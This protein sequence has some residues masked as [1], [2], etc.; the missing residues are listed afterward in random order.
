M[1]E[2]FD[3]RTNKVKE[4]LS[5]S[6]ARASA[7]TLYQATG[8]GIKVDYATKDFSGMIRTLKTMLEYA[9]NLND[10]ETLSD[11]ARLIVNSWELINREKSHD[12]RVDSTLLGIALEVLPR[13]SASDVQVPRLFEMI[14]QIQSDK[15]N[16]PQ[17]QK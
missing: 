12:K 14:N 4:D 3:E 17:S 16:T 11:I 9:I 15:S 6:A 7:A 13:L 10:A 2:M 5:I 1:K 8:I